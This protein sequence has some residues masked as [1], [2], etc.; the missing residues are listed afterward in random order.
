MDNNNATLYTHVPEDELHCGVIEL[1]N[2]D[3]IEMPQKAR[4]DRVPTPTR[5]T[6][7]GYQNNVYQVHLQK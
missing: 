4:S 1:I 2:G 6:H 7:G 5:G 3:G